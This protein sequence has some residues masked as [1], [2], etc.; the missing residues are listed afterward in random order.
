MKNR[1]F[2]ISMIAFLSFT[3]ILG[4]SC[5]DSYDMIDPPM[6]TDYDDDLDEEIMLQE[7]LES[8]FVTPFGE[9]DM[10]GSSW[11]Q[12][13]DA[14][15]FRELLTGSIDLS[16]STI[17]MSQG[18]YLMSE[19][20]GLG[21]ILRKNIQAIK[22]GYSH[23]SEGTDISQRDIKAFATIFSGDINRNKK[24]DAGDCGLLLV[25]MGFISIEG[26]TFQHGY[27]SKDDK[28]CGSGI[29][30]DG[31]IQSTSIEL[32]DCII[33]DCKSDISA[34]N[35][36]GGPA[37]YVLSGL[38]RLNRVQL[39][40]NA[41]VARG[42]AVRA[43]SDVAVIMMNRC[44]LKGNSITG[45]WGSAIQLSAGHICINNTT[46]IDNL[47]PN[48]FTVLNG[49]GSFLLTNNTLVGKGGFVDDSG[50]F[51]SETKAGGDTKFINNLF[52]SEN[53]VQYSINGKKFENFSMG[54]NIYQKA[55][56]I[57]MNS[58]DTASPDFSFGVLNE[59]GTYRWNIS[60]VSSIAGYA[61][62]QIVIDVAKSF[63]PAKSPITNLG[64][65]FVK[66]IE[67]DAFGIDQRGEMRN[68]AKMQTGAYDAGLN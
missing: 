39:L 66:W 33:R 63:N 65:A 22:G 7:G 54:Y 68:P 49:G 51:R 16:E 31:S 46:M 4:Q 23:F 45:P 41:A 55:K 26:V 1:I 9:G 17:Y 43:Q 6:V 3:M 64:E 40:D 52:V 34:T 59:D 10:D 37:V 27:A 24:A 67:E 61:T 28:D 29:Y 36:Q 15:S 19:E 53:P 12:A 57:T 56:E 48:N 5:K 42:G 13:M 25:K 8:Y 60:D 62:K 14:E 58:L 32:T 44:L 20:S 18:K 2:K 50:V 11:E 38:V 35:P 21:I 47:D 30:V